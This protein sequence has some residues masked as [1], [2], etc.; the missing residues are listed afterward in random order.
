MIRDA[1]LSGVVNDID[2][3]LHYGC[4]E[5]IDFR[6]VH[7]E[8]TLLMYACRFGHGTVVK[9]LLRAGASVSCEDT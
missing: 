5:V 6:S 3:L 1:A 2:A 4:G 9:R 7:E 8:S